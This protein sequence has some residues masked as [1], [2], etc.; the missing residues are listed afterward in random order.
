MI[1]YYHLFWIILSLTCWSCHTQEFDFELPKT[2]MQQEGDNLEWKNKTIDDRE[3][4]QTSTRLLDSI[5]WIRMHFDFKQG[6]EP[7][8]HKGI[9]LFGLGAQE[10]YW[11]GYYIGHNGQPGIDQEAEIPGQVSPYF[12]LPDSL[13]QPG[14]HVLALRF[15]QHHERSKFRFIHALVADYAELLQLP[16]IVTS[17]IHIL[18]GAYLLAAI[19]FLFLFLSHR[20]AP[21]VL[22]FSVNCFVFFSLILMEYL[23]YYV[24][25]TYDWHYTRLSVIGLLTMTAAFMVPLFFAL[26]FTLPRRRLWLGLYALV[27]L[28]FFF[29]QF[30]HGEY[31]TAARSMGEWMWISSL[32]MVGYASIRRIK[33]ASIVL[34]GLLLSGIC[35]FFFIYDIS[36]YLSFTIIVFCMFYLL[37][38]SGREEQKTYEATLLLSERLKIELLKKQIRPHFLMNTLTSLIDW[39]EE[40]PREGVKFMEALAEE[41][42]LLNQMA[43]HQLIPIAQEIQLC[44][45]HLKVMAY[46]K[47]VNY[48]WED[49]GIDEKQM[50]P[51]GLIH[52]A[53]ENGITHSMPLD[54]GS[55][56]FQLQ[57]EKQLNQ[58]EYT[59]LTIAKNRSQ[60]P[61]RKGTGLRY[62]ESRL[63]ESYGKNWQLI[64]KETN[65]GWMTQFRVFSA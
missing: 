61:L 38:V 65:E 10:V 52:T 33:G 27:L 43:D 24:P 44:K 36:L 30:L 11:D 46:R 39:V 3:W 54:D 16:L 59:L 6:L 56:R 35:D 64:S 25:Y 8:R 14:E 20:R 41:L 40:S 62:I 50:I 9:H 7:N 60:T 18:A 32:L 55:I 57:F 23:K 5:F 49:S 31:D 53:L 29:K 63:T 1:R 13:A 48:C 45:T 51:P 37:T 12:L 22:I 26:Q 58:L 34:I 19:Y 2:I 47:E 17:F 15:S 4:N 21:T 28:F 42:K